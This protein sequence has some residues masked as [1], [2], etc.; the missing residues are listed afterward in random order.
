VTG[1][2]GAGLILDFLHEHDHVPWQMFA[3]LVNDGTGEYRWP[4]RPW[5]PLTYSLRASRPIVA[6][7]AP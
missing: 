3:S 4:D 1:L 7:D 2:L 5:L 6:P